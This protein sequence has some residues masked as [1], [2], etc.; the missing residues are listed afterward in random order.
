M[1]PE[2]LGGSDSQSRQMVGRMHELLRE[3]RRE[4]NASVSAGANGCM[5]V[6]SGR[7]RFVDYSEKTKKIIPLI[8]KINL[9]NSFV[10]NNRK[11][12]SLTSYFQIIYYYFLNKF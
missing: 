5:M 6:S 4:G 10:S 8:H 11:N 7:E 9:K 3:L 2:S 1:E 12:K